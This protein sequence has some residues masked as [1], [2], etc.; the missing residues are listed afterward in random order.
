MILAL[1]PRFPL[2]WRSPTSLQLGV[3]RPVTVLPTVSVA[4][5]RMLAALQVGIP[6]PGLDLLGS[7]SG[8]DER[9]LA[10]FRRAIE[11]ALLVRRGPVKARV[12]VAGSGPT[13]DRLVWRLREAGLDPH[14][15]GEGP[16]SESAL[17]AA[18]LADGDL[19]VLVGHYVLDPEL[20]GFWLR[21]DLPHLP[22][23]YGD[24]TVRIGPLI[25]PGW[26]PCLYCLERHR[27]DAD[28]AWPVLATQLL[29]R[30]SAA[31]SPFVAG[32][33]ATIAARLLLAR[34]SGAASDAT[35]ITLDIETGA[36]ERRSWPPHPDCACSG[37]PAL[38]AETP[39]GSATASSH[40]ADARSTPTTRDEAVAV[41]A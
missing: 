39:R 19:A 15:I 7:E 24:A 17:A 34:G 4:H 6:S 30:R 3:D 18:G 35:S 12:I 8:L 11:P 40:R 29:G 2:L 38:S 9:E 36:L 1:D 37:L 26:G 21:R 25:E 31:E 13:A 33:A 32:E 23:I 10:A 27:A 16:W 28:P 22:V 14:P 41:P 5:E 20:R